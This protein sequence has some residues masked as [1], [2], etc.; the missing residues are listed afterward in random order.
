MN[1]INDYD[2]PLLRQVLLA[3]RCISTG[4]GWLRHSSAGQL[5]LSLIG[6]LNWQRSSPAGISASLAC[7]PVV[8]LQA[9]VTTRPVN[10]C[11]HSCQVFVCLGR[12]LQPLRARQRAPCAAPWPASPPYVSALGVHACC[13]HNLCGFPIRPAHPAVPCSCIP[14]QVFAPLV[15]AGF[16]EFVYGGAEVGHYCNHHPLVDSVHLTGSEA[17]YNNIMFGTPTVQVW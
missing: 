14:P 4:I 15:A 12:Y 17:T 10:T 16:L 1:P 8:G 9:V 2:G 5:R 11:L 6:F 13:I 3:P 7:V